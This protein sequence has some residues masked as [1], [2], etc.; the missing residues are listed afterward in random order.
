MKTLGMLAGFL[1]I[2]LGV[3]SGQTSWLTD[4]QARE[5]ASATVHS[6]DPQPCYSTYRDEHLESF[7]PSIQNFPVVGSELKKSVYFYNVASDSCEY[8]TQEGGKP[9]V[10]LQ[11]TMDCCEYGIVAVDRG[12]RKSYWFSG[13]KKPEI[14]A[15]FVHDEQLRPDSPKPVLFAA[16]YQELAWGGQDELSSLAQLR[17]LVQQNFRSAY[18]PYERDDRQERKF[19][20]WW[21][22]FRARASQ[23][24]LETT[25]EA[26]AIGTVVRGYAFN[27]FQLTIPRSDPP[28]KGTP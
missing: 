16:L 7:V 8:V 9:V 18:S 11:T 22:R 20:S 10:H 26:T 1:L 24:K 17:D 12:T 4:D 25:Y 3:V 19:D 23:L 14:F 21:H 15:E 6:V 13:T 2:A 27:G 5:V 28:P